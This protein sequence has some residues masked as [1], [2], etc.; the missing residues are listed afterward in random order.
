VFILTRSGF[1]G[2]QRYATATWSGDTTGTWTAMAKQIPAGLGFSISGVPYW[3]MDIG[4]YTM[5]NRFSSRNPTPEDAEEWRELNARWFQFGAFCP[6]TRLHGELLP[7]EPWAFGGDT[8]P[9]YLAIVKFDHLR[10]RLLPYLYSTAGE[11]TWN[12]ATFM[13][14]FVMDFPRDTAAREI[15]D[16]YMFGP[17]FLIAPVTTY[18][19]RSRAVYLPQ[20]GAGWYD[21]WTGA[22]AR[23]GQTLDTPAPYDSMPLFVRAGAIIPFGPE[24][25]HTGDKPADPIT[26]CVYAGADAAFTLYEDDGVTYGYERGAFARIPLHWDDNAKTLTIGKREGKYPGMLSQRTFNVVLAKKDK[27]V[28]FSFTPK[29]DKAVSYQGKAAKVK[30]D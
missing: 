26:L 27:P 10:Y 23:G 20:T 16:E 7:R 4:G 9:A 14:P 5:E 21:F 1:A 12:A 2:I 15:A 13:R 17:A 11:V 3:T 18:K 19:A 22:H 6:I 29:P 30:F 25:Q 24:I 28:G 8:H